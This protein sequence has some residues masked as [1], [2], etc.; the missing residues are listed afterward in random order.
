MRLRWKRY[1]R[2]IRRTFVSAR[3]TKAFLNDPQVLE[4]LRVHSLPIRHKYGMNCFL[5]EVFDQDGAE[6]AQRTYEEYIRVKISRKE[7][8]CRSGGAAIGLPADESF[9]AFNRAAAALAKERRDSISVSPPEAIPR[10]VFE[11]WQGE[12]DYDVMCRIWVL[13]AGFTNKATEHMKKRE[14]RQSKF[15][16]LYSSAFKDE[17]AASPAAKRE[18]GI[19]ETSVLVFT[20]NV[21]GSM[22]PDDE[23]GIRDFLSKMGQSYWQTIWVG[24][25]KHFERSHGGEGRQPLTVIDETVKEYSDALREHVLCTE[26]HLGQTYDHIKGMVVQANPE[27]PEDAVILTSCGICLRLLGYGS[28]MLEN[29]Q[30]ADAPVLRVLFLKLASESLRGSE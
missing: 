20:G 21:I 28:N 19:D 17:V 11:H 8:P 1:S 18:L 13:G 4:Y 5:N 14:L 29:V 24:L 2:E 23:S 10:S 26:Q 6:F 12:S 15:V 9:A 16:S 3:P 25:L 22:I 27:S 7:V 30:R